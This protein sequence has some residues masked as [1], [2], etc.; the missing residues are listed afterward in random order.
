MKISVVC[1][2]FSLLGLSQAKK[3]HHKKHHRKSKEY[4]VSIL[5]RK[6]YYPNQLNKNISQMHYLRTKEMD[7]IELE[8]SKNFSSI[9]K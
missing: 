2:V 4:P 8:N 5:F 7:S 1:L 6:Q 3:K 9:N